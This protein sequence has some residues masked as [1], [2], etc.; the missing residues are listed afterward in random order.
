MKVNYARLKA[1]IAQKRTP[2]VEEGSVVCL[3]VHFDPVPAHMPLDIFIL[4]SKYETF[5]ESCL[6]LKV[7]SLRRPISNRAK[8]DH[9]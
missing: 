6:A 3:S 8:N 5:T 4:N 9:I 1:F 7:S 2:H